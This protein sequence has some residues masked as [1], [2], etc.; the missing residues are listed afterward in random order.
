MQFSQGH[1]ES[2]GIPHLREGVIAIA[3]LID[4][5]NFLAASG[6][7]VYD[8]VGITSSIY[9]HELPP[10]PAV[11]LS[12]K[13]YGAAPPGPYLF[14]ATLP[15]WENPRVQIMVRDPDADAGFARCYAAWKALI[16]RGT[17]ITTGYQRVRWNVCGHYPN[18][19]SCAAIQPAPRFR[20]Q[21][22]WATEMFVAQCPPPRAIGMRWSNDR[23][24]CSTGPLQM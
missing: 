19:R 6:L 10:A 11:A 17:T 20:L 23:S 18:K 12:V 24:F 15:T 8:P 14:D 1:K 5:A 4:I 9:I 16:C 2:I 21:D 13:A 22:R 3:V 7:G